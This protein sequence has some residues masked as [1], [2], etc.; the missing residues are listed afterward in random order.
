MNFIFYEQKAKFKK[1]FYFKLNSKI[2]WYY[3][4]HKFKTLI[5]GAKWKIINN[6]FDKIFETN[7]MYL[8]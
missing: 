3:I 4:F 8:K 7:D 1:K 6:K 2:N 5:L